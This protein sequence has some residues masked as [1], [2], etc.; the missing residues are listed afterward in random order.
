[1]ELKNYKKMK[2][3]LYSISKKYL[4]IAG[5]LL[6]MFSSCDDKALLKE[7]PLDFLAP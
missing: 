5:I 7:V 1:M 3:Y 2:K 6:F 4:T